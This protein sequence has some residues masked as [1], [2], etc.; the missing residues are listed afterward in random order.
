MG[1][2]DWYAG[3]LCK[4]CHELF[5]PDG[6]ADE[7]REKEARAKAICAGCPVRRECLDYALAARERDGIWGGYTIDERELLLKIQRRRARRKTREQVT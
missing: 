5:H 1:A 7:L 4:G 6:R 2:P 3:A